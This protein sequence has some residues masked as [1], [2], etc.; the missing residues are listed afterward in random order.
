MCVCVDGWLRV[1]EMGVLLVCDLMCCCVVGGY[2][3]IAN[4]F[5]IDLW[6]EIIIKLHVYIY[7]I[8]QDRDVSPLLPL[9]FSFANRNVYAF[10]Q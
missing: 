2:K 9:S 7:N 10:S 8:K 1:C 5:H 6:W 4:A 3:S